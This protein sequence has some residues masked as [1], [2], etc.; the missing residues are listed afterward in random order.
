MG[1]GTHD[2]RNS[3]YNEIQALSEEAS[4]QINDNIALS[5]KQAGELF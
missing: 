5:S 2:E 1:A 3:I 4:Q